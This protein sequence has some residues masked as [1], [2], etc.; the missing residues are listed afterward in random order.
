VS[1]TALII[2][3]P[4][5]EQLV[6]DI[7]DSYDPAAMFG[8]PTHISVL[9]P[10]LAPKEIDHGILDKLENLFSPISSFRYRLEEIREF[11]ETLYLAPEP[12]NEFT[13]LIEAVTRRFPKYPPYGGD[14]DSTVPHLTIAFRHRRKWGRIRKNLQPSLPPGIGI[15]ACCDRITLIENSTGQ[16]QNMHEFRLCGA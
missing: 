14:H 9:Y 5:A 16:W 10:F 3:V 13:R 11:P 7:R 6:G 15:E 1:Q 8:V 2:P 4:E 12:E